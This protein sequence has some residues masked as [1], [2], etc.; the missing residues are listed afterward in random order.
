LRPRAGGQGE[1]TIEERRDVGEQQ[2]TQQPS[3]DDHELHDPEDE[4]LVDKAKDKLADLVEE[5]EGADYD[6]SKTNPVSGQPRL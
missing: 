4:S 1:L 6:E 3:N 2:R 5:P